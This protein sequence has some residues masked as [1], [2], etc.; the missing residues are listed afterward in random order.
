MIMIM[1]LPNPRDLKSLML[2]ES[3]H[4]PVQKLYSRIFADVIVYIFAM[5]IRVTHRGRQRMH[6]LNSKVERIC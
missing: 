3:L 6:K 1:V 4:A 5:S 2:N